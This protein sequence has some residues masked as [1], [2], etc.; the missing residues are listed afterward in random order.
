MMTS[1]PG[2]SGCGSLSICVFCGSRSGS[3]EVLARAAAQAGAA[4]AARRHRVIY[5]A[6][7]VGLMGTM[8]CAASMRG[9]QITGV[10]P[11]RLYD[12][13]RGYAVPGQELII[14]ADMFERKRVML[15]AADAFLALPGGYGTLD[16][17][18]EVVSLNYLGMMAKPL[19]LLNVDGIWD[20]LLTLLSDVR[21]RGLVRPEER[22][23]F[24]IADNCNDALMAIESAV[25]S[26]TQQA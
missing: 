22:P 26:S 12:I 19:A 10:I 16:E 17:I 20:S 13:E 25:D 7:G 2:A 4:I 1:S 15:N 6:G 8:A 5:G 23:P 11:Q 3:T 21:D 14:T 24:Y 9:A 18:L